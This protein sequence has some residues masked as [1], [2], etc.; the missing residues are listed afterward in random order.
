MKNKTLLLVFIHGFKGDG[1]TFASFPDHVAAVLSPSLPNTTILPLVY[2][3]YETRGDLAVAVASFRTWLLD[4]VI[5]LEVAAETPSPSVAPSVHIVLIGHSMG[6]IVAADALLG[7]AGEQ[8]I[9]PSEASHA[10]EKNTLP[11]PAT[12]LFPNIRGVLA[13]DTPYLGISPGVLAYGAEAHYQAASSTLA[14]LTGLGMFGGGAAAA[15]AAAGG[16]KSPTTRSADALKLPAAESSAKEKNDEAPGWGTWGKLAVIGGAAV[17]AAGGAA[18]YAKR[19]EIGEGVN[20]A[21]SH[22][23]FVGCLMR[24]EELKARVAGVEGV[25]A[26]AEVGWVNLYTKLGRGAEPGTGAGGRTFCN[27]PKGGKWKEELNDNAK[28]EVTAHMNMFAPAFNPGYGL[29]THHAADYILKWTGHLFTDAD[30]EAETEA[31]PG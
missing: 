1:K 6:G 2:P 4:H 23:A 30:A 10:S 17:L 15:A 8:T 13:M 31:G 16:A 27:L 21:T 25:S 29:L 14:Q 11:S 3:A 12:N 9:L 20:W 5:D 18:A 26:G 24:P 28:E 7:I 19:R 22:M